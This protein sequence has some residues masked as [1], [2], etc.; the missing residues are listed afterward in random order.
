MIDLHCHILPSVDDGSRSLEESLAMADQAVQDGI[1]TVV[2]TPHGL[3]GTYHNP[4]GP[5][6]ERVAS[7]QSIFSER[8]IP[9][10]LVP[11]GDVHL[12]PA[13]V[14]L[15][16]KGDAVTINNAGKYL[17]LE[18][19]AQTIPPGV[20]DELFALKLKGIT[21]II[22]HP[23]R[24]P[25]IVRDLQILHDLVA[26]GALSQVTAMSLT[27]GFGEMVR[28]FAAE[29]VGNRLA[30]VIA[31]D[32]HSRDRRPPVLSEAV[33]AV[34]EITGDQAYARSMVLDVPAA[35][36]RGESVDIAEPAVVKKLG[37]FR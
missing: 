13:M 11:G 32:A 21:P 36:L 34:E 7:L 29:I 19:P 33:S 16:E 17:L 4:L 9:L 2:A 18:L 27:G 25:V 24:N 35:I 28:R 31:S 22:T 5:T 10:T 20:K 12:C 8:G 26:M 23:E 15:V 1:H 14:S 3:D 37:S 30:H 6:L